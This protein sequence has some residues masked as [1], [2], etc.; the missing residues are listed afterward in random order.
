MVYDI[1]VQETM[2][3]I[4]AM[5]NKLTYKGVLKTVHYR[6]F[7]NAL[8]EYSLGAVNGIVIHEKVQISVMY[9]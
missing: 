4:T 1:T 8:I 7:P 6:I 9:N 3:A 2:H 5:V